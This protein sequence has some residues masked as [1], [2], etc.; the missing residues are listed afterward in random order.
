MYVCEAI[1][2]LEFGPNP[3]L[4]KSGLQVDYSRICIHER[5]FSDQILFFFLY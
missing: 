3:G 4:I 5:L 1:Q 2:T